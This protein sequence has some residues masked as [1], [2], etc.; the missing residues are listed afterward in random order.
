M[1]LTRPDI[2]VVERKRAL[3]RE[4]S[5]RRAGLSTEERR[6]RHDAATARLLALA[7]LGA[8]A[9][10]TVGGYVALEAK[11]EL[12][13]VA[14]LAGLAAR[15]AR[16][17]LPRVSAGDA[18]AG[19]LRFHVVP[20]GDG[21]GVALVPGPFGLREPPSTAPELAIDELAAVL[22]PGFAFDP[23]GRRVGFGGGYYDCAL[24]RRPGRA[25]PITIGVAYDFQVVDRCPAEAW[26]VGV[27][28]VVTDAR[29]LRA[30]EE[31]VA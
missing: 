1:G 19:R 7:E 29:V 13:P 10:R 17:A 15:G 21:G 4:M 26:D 2:D 5:E 12:D 31:G 25:R 27:D 9:G 22:V 11:G 28:V 14:A 16:I 24:E 8:V 6:A 18:P 23:A 3:R 20:W 30:S